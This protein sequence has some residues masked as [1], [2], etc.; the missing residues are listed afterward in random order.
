MSCRI[1][2]VDDSRAILQMLEEV[3]TYEGY[4][5]IGHLNPDHA[6]RDLERFKP[7]VI[8]LDW[9]FGREPLGRVVLD[10]LQNDP[11][12]AGYRVLVC[13]AASHLVEGIEPAL[14]A[15]GVGVLYKPFEFDDLTAALDDLLGRRTRERG[16]LGSHYSN[17]QK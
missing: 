9:L 16:T 8:I 12:G 5:Y 13:S 1:M 2:A 11:G 17:G 3:L 7:D 14:R 4:E 15:M 10:Q 6:L